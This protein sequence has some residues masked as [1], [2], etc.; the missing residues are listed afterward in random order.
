MMDVILPTASSTAVVQITVTAH[1][2]SL[3]HKISDHRLSKC[4][5]LARRGVGPS[6]IGNGHSKPMTVGAVMDDAVGEAY[7][8]EQRY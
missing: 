8:C 3:L 6:G 2:W 1:W 5:Q 7:C 4:L